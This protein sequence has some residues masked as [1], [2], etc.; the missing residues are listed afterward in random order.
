LPR[1]FHRAAKKVTIY[2]AASELARR[3]T[4]SEMGNGNARSAMR[5]RNCRPV[6]IKDFEINGSEPKQGTV[7]KWRRALEA[8]GI[9]FIEADEHDGPGLR[10]RSAKGKR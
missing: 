3:V 7:Q 5:A 9:R 8:A 4:L 10:L 1:S 2:A 6:S